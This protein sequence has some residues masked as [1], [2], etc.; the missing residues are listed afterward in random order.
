MPQSETASVQGANTTSETA[1]GLR[2][3]QIPQDGGVADSLEE[4]WREIVA[5]L[6]RNKESEDTSERLSRDPLDGAL[7][8]ASDYPEA[9]SVSRE[10]FDR[11]EDMNHHVR[12]HFDTVFNSDEV[13][14]VLK[15]GAPRTD[16]LLN[17]CEILYIDDAILRFS[18]R[19]TFN[20]SPNH[21]QSV[22][23]SELPAELDEETRHWMS[24][25]ELAWDGFIENTATQD[26]LTGLISDLYAD[27]ETI[28]RGAE[29]RSIFLPPT[30]DY[31]DDRLEEAYLRPRLMR[32]TSVSSE[33]VHDTVYSRV[34]DLLE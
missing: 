28:A 31:T 5:A 21:L 22:E 24:S 23:F 12:G 29:D 20:P 30:A 1:P 19:I 16:T 8:I 32:Q 2:Q 34:F 9:V 18:D 25:I 4:R 6:K 15:D 26:E 27:R 10:P 14:A 33:Q 17:L 13:G 11:S 3:P 7:A